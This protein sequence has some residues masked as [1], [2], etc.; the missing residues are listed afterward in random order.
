MHRYGGVTKVK[1][2]C[3]KCE[4]DLVL[5]VMVDGGPLSNGSERCAECEHSA[6]QAVS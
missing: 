5:F 3:D 1:G 4:S 6:F 2:Q